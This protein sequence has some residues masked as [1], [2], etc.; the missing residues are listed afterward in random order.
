MGK[1]SAGILPV[2]RAADG[3]RF[4]LVHPG[5]P[6]F[7]KKDAGAWTVA[8]GL[9]EPGEA[10]L[11]AARREWQEETGLALPDGPFL[12]LGSIRQKGGKE[13]AAWLIEAELDPDALVSNT[14]EIEWP[15]RSG[16]R[17]H[18]PEVDRAAWFSGAEAREKILAAQQPFLDR[19]AALVT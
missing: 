4:F 7:R 1:R 12:E 8:K 3:L 18:F 6:F 13:V 10:P 15:P 16:T 5:G 2:R 14:F 9:I 17:A 11:D 19:A